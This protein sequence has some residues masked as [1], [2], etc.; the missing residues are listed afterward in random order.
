MSYFYIVQTLGGLVG[1]A[2]NLIDA[3][4]IVANGWIHASCWCRIPKIRT[5]APHRCDVCRHNLEDMLCRC[6]RCVDALHAVYRAR[7]TGQQVFL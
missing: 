3:Q 4:R 5:S 6:P 2:T 7:Q 1:Y